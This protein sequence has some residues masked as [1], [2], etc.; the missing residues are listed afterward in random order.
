MSCN[1][2]NIVYMVLILFLYIEKRFF[3]K[4]VE[5]GYRTSHSNVIL[6]NLIWRNN[7]TKC[8]VDLDFACCKKQVM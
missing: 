4:L 3:I 8:I 7:G 5:F 6:M 1:N 2:Q